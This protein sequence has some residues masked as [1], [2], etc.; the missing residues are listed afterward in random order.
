M[1]V[2][3]A[4]TTRPSAPATPRGARPPA[5]FGLGAVLVSRP[6]PDSNGV[7]AVTA[8]GVAPEPG[9]AS[10]VG[11]IYLL[12][13]GTGKRLGKVFPVPT[14]SLMATPSNGHGERHPVFG[15]CDLD[16]DGV[17][18]LAL[19]LVSA[20]EGGPATAIVCDPLTG[21]TL[22]RLDGATLVP[23]GACGVLGRAPGQIFVRS[24]D[25]VEL[26][27]LRT[28]RFLGRLPAR[29]TPW[30]ADSGF[31]ALFALPDRNGDELLE[32]GALATRADEVT[33]H[34][35][36][37]PDWTRSA[38]ESRLT[39]ASERRVT[40]LEES[41]ELRHAS[42][43]TF[44]GGHEPEY[45]VGLPF[46]D[47]DE[48]AAFF[49][50]SDPARPVLRLSRAR[51]QRELPSLEHEAMISI[52]WSICPYTDPAGGHRLG[53]LVGV[54]DIAFG[55]FVALYSPERDAFRWFSEL[56]EDRRVGVHIVLAPDIDG[57]GAAEVLVTGGCFEPGRCEPNGSVR[58]LDGATG[59]ILWA[60]REGDLE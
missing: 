55:P 17:D 16:E 18:E 32:L 38:L 42:L 44:G 25:G 11:A 24:G 60:L 43:S 40:K 28:M 48:G 12:D 20:D 59:K 9:S 53:W 34:V 30:A 31:Q 13:V 50:S 21:R 22:R 36:L 39:N 19:D 33:L 45:S 3:G 47:G 6:G 35:L 52:G 14:G 29:A 10:G 41:L 37:S 7:L 49:A 1:D 46:V 26:R 2:G 56:S 5:L 58:L 51:L 15:V 27:D 23:M 8:P 54:P 4:S 57:D